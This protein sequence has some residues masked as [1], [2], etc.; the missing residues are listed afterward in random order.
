MASEPRVIAMRLFLIGLGMLLIYLG[1]K[2]VLEGLFEAKPVAST[3][4]R[5]EEHYLAYH[6]AHAF[7]GCRSVET[8]RR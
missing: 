8:C 4:D 1:R 5:V 2:G 3:R 6:S 7:I